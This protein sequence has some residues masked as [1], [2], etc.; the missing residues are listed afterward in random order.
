VCAAAFV[1]AA[2]VAVAVR[3]VT[4]FAHGWWLVAYL[5]LVGGVSQ[6]LLG[7][8]LSA[9]ARNANRPAPSRKTSC[10]QLVSWNAG[11]VLVAVGVLAGTP[12]GVLAGSVLL[13][14]ALGSFAASL[15][16]TGRLRGWSFGYALLVVF[17][18]SSVFVG[19]ALAGALPG[20]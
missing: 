8:G 11:T 17:L 4:P 5:G 13:L 14:A 6:L 20:Q 2:A 9:I 3:L 7:P 1:L 10:A 19:A 15:R 12:A 16:H 18:V